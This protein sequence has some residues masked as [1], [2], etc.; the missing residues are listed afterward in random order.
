M[1]Y[2]KR[3]TFRTKY[4]AA[5]LFCKSNSSTLIVC[6][7]RGPSG[8]EKVQHIKYLHDLS[9][10]IIWDELK[11][12]SGWGGGKRYR[13]N[14]GGE[15][16]CRVCSLKPLLEAS[17]IGFGLVGAFFFKGKWQ[18]VAKKGRETRIVGGG[19]KN[20]F[21]GQGQK[22]VIQLKNSQELISPN[23]SSQLQLGDS[24]ELDF[25]FN[26][27]MSTGRFSG[28]SPW[29]LLWGVPQFSGIEIST[30]NFL[31]I[32]FRNMSSHIQL[33]IVLELILT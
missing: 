28:I 9:D 10:N 33:K 5:R 18:R 16:Y 7:Q 24:P 3:R 12:G 17:E 26:W 15:T 32:N 23:M 29:V 21:D 4:L 13:V 6:R 8:Q 30:Q 11:L 22:H 31:R 19:S 25:C 14:L 20:V 1:S 27:E 2:T